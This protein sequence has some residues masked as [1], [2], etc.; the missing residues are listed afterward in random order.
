MGQYYNEHELKDMFIRECRCKH[1]DM[2]NI[3]TRIIDVLLIFNRH[4]NNIL[5]DPRLRAV[6]DTRVRWSK[7]IEVTSGYR[8]HEHNLR[9]GGVPDSY[10]TKGLA[11][12]VILTDSAI[13]QGAVFYTLE[14]AAIFLLNSGYVGGLGTYETSQF[15][16]IDLRKNIT[17][18]EGE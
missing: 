14:N 7:M 17:R 4:L 5:T 16:H 1:C 15:V 9:V 6:S 10:H 12:D 13:E 2:H 8:C 11:A 18:F 3:D